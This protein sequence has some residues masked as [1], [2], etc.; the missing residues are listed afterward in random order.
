[1]DKNN[2][3]FDVNVPETG[4]NRL[5]ARFVHLVSDAFMIETRAS[6]EKHTWRPRRR[7]KSAVKG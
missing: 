1:M 2:F 5:F 6:L 7:E 3:P 4:I